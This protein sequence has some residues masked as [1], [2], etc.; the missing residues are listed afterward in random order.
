MNLSQKELDDYWPRTCIKVEGIHDEES[1]NV[2]IAAQMDVDYDLYAPVL[3]YR[4]Y[5]IEDFQNGK[6][7]VILLVTH[8]FI[9]GVGIASVFQ[10]M[11]NKKDMLALGKNSEPT[12]LQNTMA[13]LLAPIGMIRVAIQILFLPFEKSCFKDLSGEDK[14]RV[15]RST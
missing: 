10:A 7:L 12:L 8:A 13:Q 14:S 15:V 6:G 9:D 4:W 2:F 1:L 5:L 11:T 3:P